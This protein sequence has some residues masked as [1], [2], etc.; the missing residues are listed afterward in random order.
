MAELKYGFFAD[1]VEILNSD[2]SRSV[3]LSGNVYDLFYN[4]EEYVPLIP[5]VSEKS[6]TKGLMRL[7]YELNGPIRDAG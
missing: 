2:Q 4:G 3:I 1:L 5:F 7:V 6:K